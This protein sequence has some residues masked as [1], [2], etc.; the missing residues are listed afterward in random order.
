MTFH[1]VLSHNASSLPPG[2]SVLLHNSSS[3][4][5]S[6]APRPPPS[7]AEGEPRPPP[8]RPEGGPGPVPQGALPRRASLVLHE[9]F[10][11]DPLSEHILPTM[12]HLQ[13]GEGRRGGRGGEADS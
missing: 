5:L 11:T 8:G 13:V 9:I 10:G 4:Q 6:V 3:R 7:R 1:S 2:C 12:R